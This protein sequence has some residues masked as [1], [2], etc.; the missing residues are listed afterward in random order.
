MARRTL[1]RD[2][3]ITLQAHLRLV[4]SPEIIKESVLS[5]SNLN[6]TINPNDPRTDGTLEQ[7]QSC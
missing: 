2:L 5:N 4:P 7:R 3:M 1:K 6:R